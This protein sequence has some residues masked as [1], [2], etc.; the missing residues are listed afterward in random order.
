MGDV[1]F[2]AKKGGNLGKISS[3]CRCGLVFGPLFLGI[4]G[5]LLAWP[6]QGR[7][8]MSFFA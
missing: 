1:F 4:Q 6:Y 3:F 7:L 8:G 5:F 2:W